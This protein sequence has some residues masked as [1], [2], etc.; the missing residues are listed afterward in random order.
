MQRAPRGEHGGKGIEIGIGV[1][2]DEGA[3]ASCCG[4]GIDDGFAP[5]AHGLDMGYRFP[6]PPHR[7]G[8]EEFAP[9]ADPL[10]PSRRWVAKECLKVWGNRPADAGFKRVFL[11]FCQT[12]CL[13]RP[14][15]L[16]LRKSFLLA[17]LKRGRNF[18]MYSKAISGQRHAGAQ[19][20]LSSPCRLPAQAGLAA[21]RDLKDR[22]CIART[23]AQ[24]GSIEQFQ[25]AAVAKSRRDLPSGGI[26]SNVAISSWLRT[27]G[28][29]MGNLGLPM[30]LWDY[31]LKDLH[32]LQNQKKSAGPKD[33]WPGCACGKAAIA[34]PGKKQKYIPPR[35]ERPGNPWLASFQNFQKSCLY[36]EDR[37]LQ[38]GATA[39]AGQAA[40]AP[41]LQCQT[42]ETAFFPWA[43]SII[44]FCLWKYLFFKRAYYAGS[45]A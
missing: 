44:A 1:C 20:A 26:S 17:G 3:H 7:H 16:R 40:H 13:V 28:K 21:N 4:D 22:G 24:A 42:F 45:A 10:P 31:L 6:W 32:Q 33:A 9:C 18:A 41:G 14:L 34:L 25:H 43:Y 27:S 39:P 23:R 12:Y 30:F 35:R 2:C 11:Q 5:Q 19:R 36:L 15:P 37:Q 8:Q 38:S 29:C